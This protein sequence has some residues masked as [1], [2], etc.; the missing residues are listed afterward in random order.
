MLAVLD[1]DVQTTGGY[2][3]TL[4]CRK[5]VWTE[6]REEDQYMTRESSDVCRGAVEHITRRCYKETLLI[7]LACDLHLVCKDMEQC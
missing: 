6:L 4:K 5:C 2:S 1:A 3:V 7:R